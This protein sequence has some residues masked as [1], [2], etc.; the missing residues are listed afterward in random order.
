MSNYLGFARR[1]PYLLAALVVVL[2]LPWVWMAALVPPW[3]LL[4]SIA[5]VP[6]AAFVALSLVMR[7]VNAE[8][9]GASAG[10]EVENFL[11]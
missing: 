9:E 4:I 10:A 11:K 6:F 8:D 1:H 7:D 3:A 2:F 5:L